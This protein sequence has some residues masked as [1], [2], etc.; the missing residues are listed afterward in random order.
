[1]AR[2][3]TARLGPVRIEGLERLTGGASRETWRVDAVDAAGA[4]HPLVLRRDPPG[5]PGPSGAMRREADALRV[6]GAAGLAVPEVVA[7]SE[8]PACWGS[9]GIVMARVEGQALA[10]RI[11]RDDAYAGARARL[12][13]DCGRFL[14]GLHALDPGAVPGLEA[15]DQLA[16]WRDALDFTGGSS[17]TFELALRWLDAHRPPA[18]GTLARPAIVHGDFR[19]GNLLVG[20]DGLRAV[21][22]W[23]LVHAGDPIEDLGWLCV[24]A[25][26]FGAEPPVGGF[27]RREQL[28]EA[29][30]AAGGR[31][32]DPEALRW[33]EV[34]GTLR[35]GVI[36]L[37]Q[38]DAHLTG[39]LRSVELAAIGRRVCEQ[40][41]DLLLLLAPDAVAAVAPRLAA[42]DR[43]DA[44]APT[45]D[46]GLH[47]RPT[48]G[49]LLAAVREY[50]RDDVM[51]GTTGRLAYHARVAAN[52]L[53]VV[54]RELVAGPD[55]VG[56]HRTGL[57]LLGAASDAE[58]AAA[59]RS[60][61]LAGRDGDVIGVLARAVADKLAVANPRYAG[62]SAGAGGGSDG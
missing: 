7:A 16:R 23:E 60:G 49:E 4:V 33:W 35:W 41:W 24:R 8:D 40:E 19:L 55:P 42:A 2:A 21:L 26:R 46:P 37:G 12:A 59:L 57:A 14:A 38:V 3:L 1:V 44:T 53:A 20:P 61:A 32:V 36:C 62:T 50:L 13:G 30:V 10:R 43:S 29:Y 25:W 58:L 22:D 18:S 28:V 27:G 48:A 17:P 6:A 45:A 5:R 34:F 51:P 54:E 11:L 56:A 15:G 31:P 52:V 39:A 9:A 47:G